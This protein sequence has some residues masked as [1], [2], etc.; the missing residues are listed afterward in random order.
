MA[1]PVGLR[2][3]VLDTRMRGRVCSSPNDEGRFYKGPMKDP[4]PPWLQESLSP[5]AADD[6]VSV[7]RRAPALLMD[8][9]LQGERLGGFP[10]NFLRQ[11]Q[12]SG[13]SS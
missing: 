11:Q 12:A 2:R 10:M 7:P 3:G 1:E 4:A 6:H 9:T 5:V 8:F 13:L